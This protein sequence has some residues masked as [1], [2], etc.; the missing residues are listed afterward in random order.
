MLEIRVCAQHHN[1]GIEVDCHW[2]TRVPGLYAC[3]EA[4]G[5]FGRYRPGGTALNS[6]QVGSMRA[7][8]HIA[9]TRHPLPAALPP[10]DL[11]LAPAGDAAALIAELQQEMSRHGAFVRSPAGMRRLL[12]RIDE[13]E[14]SCLPAE[15]GDPDLEGRLRLLDL[16]QVQK[17]VLHAMLYDAEHPGEGVLETCGGLCRRRPARP[18]P[19]R[20]LWFERV[21]RARREEKEETLL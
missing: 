9:A 17:Q 20:D 4:A 1:G 10:A 21:W 8:R 2:Q 5:T 19:Q 15:W 16:M 14:A 13:L 18:I 3:G 6:T 11:P 7:A 12:A